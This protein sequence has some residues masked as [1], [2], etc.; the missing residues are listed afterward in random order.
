V[1][2]H[3]IGHRLDLAL[4]EQAAAWA[5]GF[6][7]ATAETWDDEQLLRFDQAHY[8]RQGRHLETYLERI[9]A[10]DRPLVEHALARYSEL[11]KL[12]D[13]L[14]QSLIHGEFF[15]K[16]VMIRPVRPPT[17][18]PLSTGRRWRP[19][20]IMS[21]SSASVRVA[22]RG[23]S[24]WR[25]GEPTSRPGAQRQV[26]HPSTHRLWKML[27]GSAS[28]TRSTSWPSFKPSPGWDSG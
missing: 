9:A 28:T 13:R 12:V 20:R 4:Y 11:V 5:G 1:G 16:N 25:C 6:H 23:P 22:G 26:A 18:S 15:G 24:G 8:E 17:R 2:P 27:P 7:A 14:P 10:A 3:R 21:T 19:D